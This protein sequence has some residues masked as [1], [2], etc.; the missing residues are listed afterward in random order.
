MKV[1][2]QGVAVLALMALAA[3]TTTNPQSPPPGLVET[4][5][6]GGVTAQ[7]VVPPDESA[8]IG[9]YQ[10]FVSFPDGITQ[11]I[12]GERDGSVTKTWLTDLTGNGQPGVLVWMTSAGSG[13]YGSLHLYEMREGRFSRRPLQS[14]TDAQRLGYMGHD[15]FTVSKGNIERRFPRYREADSNAKPTGGTA[16]FV[17]AFEIEGWVEP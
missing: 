1:L 12:Q 11:R 6:C 8:S 10:V 7:V 17:Y 15:V 2:R 13:A 4:I 14:L 9:T 5:E 16:C 3:C